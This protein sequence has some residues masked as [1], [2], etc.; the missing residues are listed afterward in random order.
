MSDRLPL[1]EGKVN[2]H[3]KLVI[4]PSGVT[5]SKIELWTR[6]FANVAESIAMLAF[7]VLAVVIIWSSL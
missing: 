3:G 4:R 2:S 5:V 6:V 1:L 7:T